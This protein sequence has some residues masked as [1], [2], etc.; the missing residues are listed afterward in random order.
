MQQLRFLI[1]NISLHIFHKFASLFQPLHHHCMKKTF[2]LLL[3]CV[4]IQSAKA[5]IPTWADNIACIAFTR[6]TGCH[7]TGGIAPFSMIDYASAFPYSSLI[8]LMV[9]D[10]KM[11]PWPPDPNY[12]TYAHERVL[13]QQEIDLINDWVNNGS[14]QGNPGNTPTP[15]VY[16]GNAQITSPDLSVVMP[17]YTVPAVGYDLYRCFVIQNVTAI[18]QFITGIEVLPGNNNIVHHVLIYADTSQTCIILDNIDPDPGYTSFGGVGSNTANLIGAW[19]PGAQP[20]FLPATMGIKLPAN[21]HIIMQVHYPLGS[22]GQ[23]D[24]TRVNMQLTTNASTRNVYIVP[25]LNHSTNLVNGPLFIPAYTVQTFNAQQ[26]TPI[27]LTVLAVAPHMHLIGTEISSWAVTILNDTI[28]LID[29]P[30]WDFHWQ[31]A[32]S[33]RQPVKIPAGATLYS[34]AT[35]DNTPNNPNNPS[36]PP[37]DVSLGEATTDE[38]MLIYFYFLPYV[39]GDENII[40]DTSTTVQTFNN[41]TFALG[42]NQPQHPSYQIS[43]YPNPSGE[44]IKIYFPHGAEYAVTIADITGRTVS[45]A[46]NIKSAFEFDCRKLS[47]GSY[48]ISAVSGNKVYREK[49][50]V[51][52]Y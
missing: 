30:E 33:F 36:V 52:H 12:Q 37:V 26:L 46:G 5:Q 45:S 16:N 29:I 49:F 24:S 1:S 4:L 43:V 18:D 40:V 20:Y 47:A 48:F 41:C 25:L 3:L 17:T 44:L 22:S 39:S 35:Y 21:S 51:I 32:Y 9:N 2:T 50:E 19:V 31:G 28:E 34:A 13:T 42:I 10:R 23:V 11:P 7:H 8:Q 27:A 38:M 14:P 6:C 15:P